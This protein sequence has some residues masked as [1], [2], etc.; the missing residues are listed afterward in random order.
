[1]SLLEGLNPSQLQA[2]THGEGPFL[3]VAGA[4]TGK[5]T[6]VTRRIA[7]LI[8]ER[9][10]P[11][12]S[13][14][15]LTFTEKAAS[16]MEERLDRLLPYGYVDLWVSTFHSFC[17]RI[18]RA[19][20][21]EIGLSMDFTLLDSVRQ[22]MMFRQNWEAFS[23][24]YLA[25]RGNPGSLIHELLSHFSRAK[26]EEI[27]EKEY[28]D[29]AEKNFAEAEDF[30]ALASDANREEAQTRFL[31]AKKTREIASAYHQYQQILYKN[32]ALDFGDLIRFTLRLFR[33]RPAI[34]AK[35]QN[36]F[37]YVLVDEFQ[38]T[39]WAQFELVRLLST[40]RNN[41]TVVADD[42]QSIYR[43][44]GAS[45]SNILEFK[46][47]YPSSDQV[48]L[49]ENYRSTQNILDLSYQFILHNNPNRLEYQM[50]QSLSS[51][52]D[53]RAENFQ[54][55]HLGQTIS[56]KL[57]SS[58]PEAGVI[59]HLSFPSQQEE[60]DGVV[61]KIQACRAKDATLGWKDFAILVR[62]NHYSEAFIDSLS[63]EGIPFTLL[64]SRGLYAKPA[65]MDILAYLRWMHFY[66]DTVSAYRVLSMP[67]WELT[68][69]E[70]VDLM[71]IA[72]RKGWH[73]YTV[74]EKAPAMGFGEETLKKCAR[75]LS[76]LVDHSAKA[77][78]GL[79]V[80]SLI[81]GFISESGYLRYL[82]GLG[83]KIYAENISYINQFL[84]MV[85][86][87]EKENK[88]HSLGA[89]L[90]YM[91]WLDEAGDEGTLR[92]ES[93][94]DPD[95]VKIMTVHASK[96]LEFRHVFIVNLV[97]QRFPTNH[98]SEA[99]PL[100]A[101]L[102]KEILPGGDFHLEEERRLFY[103]ACTRAKEGLYFTRAENYGGVR[104]KKMSRFLVEL[105][106]KDAE[107]EGK[108]LAR[109][110]ILTP[111]GSS[112][113]G[114]EIEGDDFFDWEKLIPKKFSFTQ[115]KA[116]ATC[117]WQYRYAHLLKIPT[118]GRETF[119]FGQTMHLTFERF[120]QQMID[121]R[122]SPQLGLFGAPTVQIAPSL[123]TLLS[124]Y[125]SA[126]I[127]DWYETKERQEERKEEG[128][129]ILRDFYRIHESAWP[130]VLSLEQGF[131]LKI[132]G[133]RLSGKI[134]RIDDLGDGTV[135]IVDYKTGRVPKDEAKIDPENKK[136]LLIYQWAAEEIL[137]KKVGK[138]SFYYLEENKKISFVG[139]PDNLLKLKEEILETI[140]AIRKSQ[141]IAKPSPQVCQ[142]CD[143]KSICPY[144]A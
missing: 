55:L 114:K 48:F 31:E 105:G 26:D 99:L 46:K 100:P 136:Q 92:D 62:A 95:T 123:D 30:A 37:Q 96:G 14:L 22:W 20:A 24:D 54:P 74:L 67:F 137:Q 130:L 65:I 80:F 89:F 16:E 129:K 77:K 86:L 84:K 82:E 21:L 43:F 41:L 56:K 23:F 102:I 78:R 133:Y 113:H 76:S 19:H 132:G 18:L 25:P 97:D 126:W 27:G 9:K 57:L 115:I 87:F 83:D 122:G 40:P 79:R 33:E 42:D 110:I 38:D 4:G 47:R 143:F 5:T 10:V 35:Y 116:F 15:A 98:R 109:K 1:M 45:M 51:V 107:S 59:D 6:V 2:V 34:L 17:E 66:P 88:E 138:V 104:K 142:Y 71:S 60:A 44:R 29:W 101:P 106:Y 12:D 49:T 135:E 140:E 8:M 3:I 70:M 127:D 90:R 36:Q 50:Q 72:R 118:P 125:E 39:N 7:H 108:K 112:G 117:P 128:R 61:A 73:M 64:S 121:K 13:V 75:I 91:E 103:V 32:G 120:F 119:S 85:R 131:S 94:W 93:D 28:W 63:R 144:K 139:T 81:H 134:D 52:A 124:L 141:F 69:G 68:H 58:K 111:D 11:T 53:V